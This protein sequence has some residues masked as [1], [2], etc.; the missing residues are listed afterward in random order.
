MNSS[1]TREDL[2]IHQTFVMNV[3]QNTMDTKDTT[4]NQEA[5]SMINDLLELTRSILQECDKDPDLNNLAIKYILNQKQLLEKL[6]D[7][8]L[9]N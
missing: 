9:I 4:K 1:F 8:F 3:I 2:V 7:I 5:V 6:R